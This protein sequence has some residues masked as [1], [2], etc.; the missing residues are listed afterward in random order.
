MGKLRFAILGCGRMG[1]HHSEQLLA[2]G[3]GEVTSLF[4]VSPAT[5]AGLQQ[6]LWPDARVYETFAEL[7][8][9]ADVDAAIICTPT[10]EH[11]TQ[12]TACLN[13]DWHVLCEKPLGSNREEIL[14]LIAAGDSAAQRHQAFSLGYQRRHAALYRTLRR[15]V[16]SGKWGRIRAVV[17]HNVENWQPTIAG[18]WRDDPQ[19]NPGGFLTDAGSHKLDQLFYVT[20]LQPQE[21]FARSQTCGSHVEIVTS[22]SVLLDNDVTA[23]I[24][25]IGHAQYLGE[26]LCLHC[27]HAD[28]MIRHGELWIGRG[29]RRDQLPVDEPDSNPVASLLDTILNG[30]EDRS[31]PAAAL[32]VYDL[33]QAMLES[34]RSGFPVTI[35][36]S[37][38]TYVPPLANRPR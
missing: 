38:G 26:D 30:A 8:T 15:E 17:S 7:I 22:A 9:A 37:G 1:R 20:G 16:R 12:A 24:D 3:R 4:D 2:D 28:L 14:A 18:T 29:G 6:A 36:A 35:T 13:R 32:P 23:T 31:P 19:Q 10:A 34:S 33:T 27:E 11:F 21:V 25:F 5:A